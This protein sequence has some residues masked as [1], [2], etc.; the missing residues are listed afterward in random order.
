MRRLVPAAVLILAA[1][2]PA[3][4]DILLLRGGGRVEGAVVTQGDEYVVTT[5]TGRARVK[6][7][8]VLE[9]VVAP[10]VTE[11]YESRL[12]R[13]DRSDPDAW[14]ALSRWAFGHGLPERGRKRLEE[15]I[16]L[17]PDHAG[18][19]A[20]L[21]QVKFE[22][23]WMMREEAKEARLGAAG[24]VRFEGRWYTP[25]GLAALVAAKKELARLS[26]EEA[27]RA[28]ERAAEEKKRREEEELR[29]REEAERKAREDALA[30][31]EEDRRERERLARE[32]EDLRDLV[33]DLLR[34]QAFDDYRY[35][36]GVTFGWVGP[37]PLAPPLRR[38]LRPFPSG[39][40]L[41]FRYTGDHFQI[42]GR[43]R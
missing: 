43:V 19:R 16:R 30:R 40:G 27:E 2:A 24:F 26:E 3:R 32:N 14:F 41:D 13:L 8:D 28:A 5:L 12:A 21:G 10:Y 34:R 11:Q 20:A 6:K 22:G 17:A 15:V 35:R 31:A 39:L 9:R 29:A 36:S 25:E 38:T 37:Y 33:R 4:A 18:A 42:R 7:T 1:I 23:V